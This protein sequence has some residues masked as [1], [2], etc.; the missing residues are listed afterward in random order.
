MK[1]AFIVG[2]C[3]TKYPEIFYVWER[4]RMAGLET[5]IIDTSIRERRLPAGLGEVVSLRERDV[6]F[7][8]AVKDRSEALAAMG[9]LLE[10]CLAEREAEIGGVLG[11]GGSGN[12]ELTTRGMRALSVGLPKLMVSTMA[13]GNVAPYVGL[14][15]I[16]LMPSVADVQGLNLITRRI[17]GNAAHALVGMIRF[18]LPPEP[19]GKSVLGMT[20]FGVTTRCVQ[21]VCSLLP[22]NYEPLVFHAN[23][24]GGCSL[25]KFIDKGTIR[26]VMDITLTEVC[27]LL[28]GGAFSAGDD[29]LGAIIRSG[30]PYVGS[31]G[32]LDMVTFSA[33]PTVPERYRSGRKLHMHS[34]C[35]TLMRTTVQ[36]NTMMGRWIGLRLNRCMGKVRFL[37]PE[38]GVSSMDAPGQPFYDPAATKALF[39]A[40]EA[41]VEQNA[42]RKLVRVPCHINDPEFALALME[43][44]TDITQSS[45]S[46]C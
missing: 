31:V 24:S 16:S 30:I 4:V 7:F 5:C 8:D 41:V 6:L 2:T 29:R 15:D 34:E 33:L 13:T 10:A 32:A 20:M 35:V 46:E 19:Q 38:G 45:L 14:T 9:S 17:L 36:E 3:D 40:L 26:N 22:D 28:M 39:A 21:Q 37:L 18:P 11:L 25:E 12:T 23:G 27:D 44:F 42:D 43:N 1:K